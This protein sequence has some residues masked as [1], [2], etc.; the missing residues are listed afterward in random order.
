MEKI[1]FEEEKHQVI[2]NI[3]K[4]TNIKVVRTISIETTNIG[5]SIINSDEF[6]IIK[7]GRLKMTLENKKA[8]KELIAM[9]TEI[10]NKEE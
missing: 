1:I 8:V 5:R 4:G 9:L 10:L 6:A 2:K 3:L 7:E